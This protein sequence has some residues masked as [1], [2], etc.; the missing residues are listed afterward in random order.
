MNSKCDYSNKLQT[1]AGLKISVLLFRTCR[2]NELQD[3]TYMYNVDIANF[4][5]GP[6]EL[7]A[8]S[9]NFCLKWS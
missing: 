1:T 4:Q 7:K 6:L 5:V 8:V 2:V 3:P 9:C